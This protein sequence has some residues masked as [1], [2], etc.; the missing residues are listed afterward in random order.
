M[1]HQIPIPVSTRNLECWFIETR[2]APSGIFLCLQHLMR[3]ERRDVLLLL[4]WSQIIGAPQRTAPV[5]VLKL[6]IAGNSHRIGRV[7]SG[8]QEDLLA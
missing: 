7:R 3:I 5:K 4:C 2:T 8:Q 1:E 6:P